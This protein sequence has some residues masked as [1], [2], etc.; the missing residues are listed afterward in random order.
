MKLTEHFDLEEFTDSQTADRVGID[1]TPPPEAIEA[2]RALCTHVLEPLRA[3]LGPVSISSGYRCL[4]LNRAIRSKDSS[5]HVRGEAADISV[6]G[7][8]LAEVFNWLQAGGGFDQLIREF[9]PRGWVHVSYAYV[10]TTQRGM[11]LLAILQKDGST[12]YPLQ[13]GPVEA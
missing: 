4:A 13:P 7:L 3:A 2:M 1:N 9:P 12:A 11:S 6:K 5:Q 8:T 10:R